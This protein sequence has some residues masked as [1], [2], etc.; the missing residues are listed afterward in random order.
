M[1]P[2]VGNRDALLRFVAILIALAAAL[3]AAYAALAYGIVCSESVDHECVGG[4]G[5]G[6][7]LIAQIFVALAGAVLAAAMLNR[8]WRR[9]WRTAAWLL[10]LTFAAFGIWGV[11]LAAAT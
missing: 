1:R 10:A 2:P 6:W 8:V 3:C 5:P 4:R 11:L 9:A 7:G